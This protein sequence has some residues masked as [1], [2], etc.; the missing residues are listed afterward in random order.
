VTASG[1]LDQPASVDVYAAVQGTEP[2]AIELLDELVLRVGSAPTSASHTSMSFPETR[3][4]WAQLGATEQGAD[5]RPP[6]EVTQPQHLFARSEFFRRPLPD[7]AIAALVAT[8]SSART[9]GVSLELDFMPWG[10]AYNR[11]PPDA[12]AFV[13]SAELFQLKRAAVVD[14]PVTT[15]AAAARRWVTQSWTSVHPWGSARVFQN[16]ADP[17]LEDWA[18]AY[19]GTNY[20]RLLKVKARYDPGNRFRFRQ[21]PRVG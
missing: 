17:D 10:G 18:E 8:F 9:S 3:R 11:V 2:E 15:S 19:Y 6:P 14:P 4:L 20:D 16:F 1:D 12:T 5:D 21:S 13:H 7:D